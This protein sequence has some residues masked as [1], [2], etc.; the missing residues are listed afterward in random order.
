MID[1]QMLEKLNDQINEELTASYLYLSMSA[2]FS[3]T[4][5]AGFARWM[6]VQAGEER[7]HAMR[8]Y[9]YINE[10]N[11]RVRLKAIAEPPNRF[12][13]HLSVFE[14]AF[15][16]EQEVTRKINDLMNLAIKLGDHATQIFLHWFVTEQ[17]EEEATA[18]RIINELKLVGDDGS[19]LLR[20]G[21][22]LGSRSEE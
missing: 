8:I 17:V 5:M 10:R 22:E 15:A 20:L 21:R 4:G 7:G 2:H 16:H 11:G 12:N 13:T 18:D 3:A 6:R 9:D 1:A 19:G 14:Q